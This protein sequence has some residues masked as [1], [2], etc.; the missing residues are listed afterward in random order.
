[1]LY[2]MNIYNQNS[3]SQYWMSFELEI[4]NK[5]GDKMLMGEAIQENS[6]DKMILNCWFAC[7]LD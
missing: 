2:Y 4:T 5:S 6:H 1:M 7:K 3:F